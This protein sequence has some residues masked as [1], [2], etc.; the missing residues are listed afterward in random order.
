MT[1]SARLAMIFSCVGHF[2][3]HMMTAFYFVIVL[4]L[5]VEWDQPYSE[6][7]RLWT[8]ASA[9]L[10][11][12]AI[13]A[14]R[15]ADRWSV[16]GTM[17]IFFIGMGVSS[18]V[19][20]M[21]ST[22]LALLLALSGIGIFGAIYHPVGIP[23]LIR[24]TTKNTGKTLA[25]NGIFG[26]LGNAGAAV[27]AGVLIDL[28]GWRMT[29]IIPGVVCGVTGLWMWWFVLRDRIIDGAGPDESEIQNANKYDLIRVALLLLVSL[30]IGGIIYQSTQ[31]ALP[32]HFTNELQDWSLQLFGAITF[33]TKSATGLGMLVSIV[34]SSSIIMQYVG[35]ALA[36]RYPLKNIYI[37]CWFLQ[38]GMLAAIAAT[39]GLGLLGSALL[40]V[41]VNIT[42]LP[43][44]NMLIYKYAPSRHRSLIFGIK[45]VITFG[46]APASVALVAYIQEVTNALDML[47]A[48]LAAATLVVALLMMFLP[49][50]KSDISEE[51]S[52]K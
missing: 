17:V 37:I 39:T 6:L 11:L 51:A 42:M 44:E 25:V 49:A 32:K 47:F 21:V 14:G 12:V 15:L 5:V 9:L 46:A 28:Y 31:T 29:F 19:C 52:A 45:F 4:T 35:G 23:W 2:Y 40:A 7:L 10:A 34:Y 3:I 16:R 43:A 13:P 38:I 18:V 24:S 26:S 20:G 27:I 36:D 50:D 1:A 33:D 48:G 41:A 30:A 8:I 22:N